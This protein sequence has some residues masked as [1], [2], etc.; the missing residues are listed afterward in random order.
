M[1]R[2]TLF[3]A[4]VA[5]A[6]ACE[7]PTTPATCDDP[8][9]TQAYPGY[10]AEREVCFEAVGD[11][12][13]YTATSS[14]PD[15]VTAGISGTTLTVTGHELGDAR[16]T[17]TARDSD[18]TSETVVYPV[19]TADAVTASFT[20]SIQPDSDDPD[21]Y[22]VDWE[23]PFTVHVGLAELYI[24]LTIGDWSHVRLLA[25][26][27][28]PGTHHVWTGGAVNADLVNSDEC[29]VEIADY[30]YADD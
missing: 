30:V 4:L 19:V 13:T 2:S 8:G 11:G 20:C 17:I 15:V 28:H 14:N 16:V 18:G 23:G 26:D 7:S 21:F 27:L 5:L 25:E 22:E 1:R 3:L 9:P 6:F 10:P 24:R 12:A 29:S